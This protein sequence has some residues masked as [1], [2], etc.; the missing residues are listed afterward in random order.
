MMVFSNLY[1][2]GNLEINFQKRL[3]QKKYFGFFFIEISAPLGLDMMKIHYRLGCER[4]A[5][6]LSST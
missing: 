5:N 1:I 2:S 4:H 6:V 3:F